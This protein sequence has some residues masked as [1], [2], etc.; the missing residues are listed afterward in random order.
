M[1]IPATFGRGREESG[2]RG[3]RAFIDVGRPHVE[4]HR[5]DLETE[6]DEHEHQAEDQA[7]IGAL[8]ACLGDPGKADGAGE[9]VDQRRAVQ[10]HAGRQRAQHEIL[11][12]GLGRAHVF[13]VRGGHHVERQAHHLEPEIE[14]DQVV[15]GNQQHHAER[16]QQEQH[17]VF[18]PLLV[19]DREPIDRQHQRAAGTGERQELEETAI[20]VDHQAAAEQFG[21]AGRQPHHGRRGQGQH[22]DA[23][24]VHDHR[25]A[26][27]L[28]RADARHQH[29]HG[30][31]RQN[32]F[33]QDRQVGMQLRQ[34]VHR[35]ALT[36]I[37]SARSNLMAAPVVATLSGAGSAAMACL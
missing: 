31:D 27:A 15:G 32:G 17:A 26:F 10:Q 25:T 24:A 29:H 2:H 1:A 21:A 37:I 20:I 14:R 18:E 33:R 19:L 23:E 12:A 35:A 8:P 13:A 36:G 3:R 22:G 11:Q 7:E 34:L 9:A 16:R 28:M 6:T 4:R 30:A 5:R